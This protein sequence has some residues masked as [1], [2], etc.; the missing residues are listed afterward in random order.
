MKVIKVLTKKSAL[1][2]LNTGYTVVLTTDGHWNMTGPNLEYEAGNYEL[3]FREGQWF[4]NYG[5]NVNPKDVPAPVREVF[6]F[7]DIIEWEAKEE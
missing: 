5:T 7:R 6:K 1:Y 3:Q 4:V 2:L